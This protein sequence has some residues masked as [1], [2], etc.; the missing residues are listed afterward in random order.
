MSKI[1]QIIGISHGS[2]SEILRVIPSNYFNFHLG[3]G[4]ILLR[5]SLKKLQGLTGIILL[6]CSKKPQFYM[7]GRKIY[8]INNYFLSFKIT[9]QKQRCF[10]SKMKIAILDSLS[11]LW[12]IFFLFNFLTRRFFRECWSLY[13]YS[14]WIDKL[15]IPSANGHT[16]KFKSKY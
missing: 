6:E 4:I 13:P 3:D 12:L 14:Q 10:L 16:P 5:N 11:L 8:N 15:N 1:F 2:V 7:R 9:S